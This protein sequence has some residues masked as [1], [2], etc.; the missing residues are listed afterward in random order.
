MNKVI[1]IFFIIFSCFLY[2]NDVNL[3]QENLNNLPIKRNKI[4]M[5]GGKTQGYGGFKFKDLNSSNIQK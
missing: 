2:A 5:H 4:D 1:F 3:N